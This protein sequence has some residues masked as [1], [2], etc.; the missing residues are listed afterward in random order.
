LIHGNFFETVSV[1]ELIK[2]SFSQVIDERRKASG[3]EI[4]QE[5]LDEFLSILAEQESFSK[6]REVKKASVKLRFRIMTEVQSE[7]NIL[8]AKQYPQIKDNT[9]NLAVPCHDENGERD[10][11][12]KMIL[13]LGAEQLKAF[14]VFR[15]K[16]HRNGEFLVFQTKLK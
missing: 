11:R 10:T 16:H 1:N 6:T 13:A 3:V 15:I 2:Q 12:H 8:N 14:D 7:G 5:S 9:L 4:S